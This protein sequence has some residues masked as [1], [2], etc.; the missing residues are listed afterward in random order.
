MANFEL[1]AKPYFQILHNLIRQSDIEY[2]AE[3]A[4]KTMNWVLENATT[5]RKITGTAEW[6]V[7]MALY[8]FW[9]KHKVA[10]NTKELDLLLREKQ[11]NQGMLDVMVEYEKY[12]PD[13][14]PASP[15]GLPLYMDQRKADYEKF[16]LLRT[17][18]I[19]GQIVVGSVPMKDKKVTY[20]GPRDA[21]KYFHDRLQQ[22]VLIDDA[23]H[24]GGDLAKDVIPEVSRR[25]SRAANGF[26]SSIKTFTPI[27][28]AMSIGPEAELKFV[29]L[30]GFTNQRKSTLTFTLAFQAA[31]QGYRVCFMALEGG[32]ENAGLRFAYLYAH[33]TGRAHLLPRLADALK[34]RHAKREHANL[35]HQMR[36]EM[37]AEGIRIDIRDALDWA[38]IRAC[39][40]AHVDDPFDALFVD[41]LAHVKIPGARVNERRDAV[42][43]VF[44]AA[45]NLSLNYEKRGLV[46]FSPLQVRKDAEAAAAAPDG[47]FDIGIYPLG[48]I[49]IIDWYTDAG[50]DLDALIGV[51]SGGELREKGLARISCVKSKQEEFQPFFMRVDP[52]TQMMTYCSDSEAGDI[53]AGRVSTRDQPTCVSPE[54]AD[55]GEYATRSR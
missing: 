11:Q 35:V 6:G 52:H 15:L 26:G 45:Q 24:H 46:V 37:Q 31:L 27:D 49:G 7:V 16:Q 55:L 29:G 23:E 18:D 36:E 48:D 47:V 8:A 12:R 40:E 10:P 25:I 4:A 1:D 33:H 14:E 21:L 17:L 38:S 44:R 42:L 51:W 20:T 34:P 53:L 50:R 30:A 43:E 41:Y 2:D 39:V 9:D 19:A 54:A 22:G 3:I 5:L 28:E 13:L 32:V